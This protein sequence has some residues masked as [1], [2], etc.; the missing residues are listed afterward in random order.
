MM[1]EELYKTAEKLIQG[2]VILYPTDTIWGIGCDATNQKAVQKIYEIKLRTDSKSMLVLMS[3][4]QM[5]YN[6]L[7]KV[8]KK[9]LEIINTA[10]KPTTIIY[11]GAIHLAPNLLGADGSIGI[12]ITADPFCRRLIELSGVPIVSTSANISGKSSPASFGEIEQGLFD[13]VDYVV[14]WRQDE[15]TK[16]VASSIVKVNEQG[17]TTLIRP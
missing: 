8:P 4:P 14:G 2:Y 5:L 17:E 16:A 1:D 12:R 3:E 6:Y 13:R 15:I 10:T 9:A 7:K 11:P